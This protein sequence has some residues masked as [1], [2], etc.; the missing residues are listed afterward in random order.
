MSICHPKEMYMNTTLR[1]TLS[2]LL[3]G[4][5]TLLTATLPKD[6]V[7]QWNLDKAWQI[8]SSHR[9]KICI[10]GLWDFLPT[11][12]QKP[13]IKT[14]LYLKDDLEDGLDSTWQ[15]LNSDS[16]SIKAT[17]D[18]E[19]KTT[20]NASM[21]F[22]LDVK[23]STNLYH[24]AKYIKDLPTQKE[25]ILSMD[26]YTKMDAGSLKVEIQDAAGY[27]K[28]CKQGHVFT[29][30][31][32]WNRV[33]IPFSLP[34]GTQNTKCIIFRSM[35]ASAGVKGTIWIDN[36]QVTS[37]D[38][39]PIV[40]NN[41]PD[42]ATWGKAKVP[43]SWMATA[44]PDTKAGNINL[45]ALDFGWFKRDVHIPAEW[46]GRIIKVTFDRASTKATVF[47]NGK[48]AGHADF[49]GGDIDITPFVKAGSKAEIAVFVEAYPYW[50]VYQPLIQQPAK[51]WAARC[52]NK[53]ITGDVFLTSEPKSQHKITFTRIETIAEGR[54]LL[55]HSDVTAPDGTQFDTQC[56]LSEYPSNNVVKT[57]TNKA[58]VKNGR[59]VIENAWQDVKLWDVAKPNLYTLKLA[60]VKD[61][62][63]QDE[64]VPIR[65]GF[66]EFRIVGKH[67]YL[68]QTKINLQTGSYWARNFNWGTKEA[69]RHWLLKAQK[70]GFT[71]IYL[72]SMYRP[73][74]QDV[75]RHFLDVCD[76]IGMLAAI[77]PLSIRTVGV[78]HM[79]STERWD[80]WK[81]LAKH[82]VTKA[83]NSPSLVL[84]RMNMNIRCYAQDQNPLL[85]DGKMTFNPDSESAKLEK[86]A[87]MSNDYVN[88]IDPSRHTYNHASGRI[89][90]IYSLNNY[91]GWP[92]L[93]DLREW[94]R[95]WAK[96]GDKPFLLAEQATPYP[97]DFQM[98]DPNVWW[99]N[100]PIMTEYGAI[101]L[102][103][104]AYHLEEY[105]YV[106]YIKR[107]WHEKNK[108]WNSSYGY[109]CSNFPP[110]LDKS[111]AIYYETML[112]AWR[113][114]GLNAGNNAWENTFRRP[115]KRTPGTSNRPIP[116]P[117]ALKTDW[118][119]LQRP[120]VSADTWSYTSGGGGEMRTLFDLDL[121][122]EKEYL[123]PTIRGSL[124]PQLIAPLY[125]YIAGP[126]DAWYT[127]EHAFNEGETIAKSVIILNDARHE[128]TFTMNW[129]ATIDGKT[130]A[131]GT[132]KPVTVKP[133]EQARLQFNFKAPEVTTKTNAIIS[134]TVSVNGKLLPIKPFHVQIHNVQKDGWM[135]LKDFYVLDPVSSTSW[136]ALE[137]MR[138]E[139]SRISYTDELPANAK[140]LIIGPYALEQCAGKPIFK[141]IKER[142]RN[143]L[144]VLI[145]P[146]SA[147]A[148]N[149]VFGLRAFTPGIRRLNIRDHRSPLIG[150]IT[151][152]DIIDWRGKTSFGPLAGPPP[153]L[154]TKQRAMRVWRCSQEGVVASTVLEKPHSTAIR[155]ILDTGFDLRYSALSEIPEGKGRI[156]L[157]QLDLY[158]R[159]NHDPNAVKLFRSIIT[160]MRDNKSSVQ[161]V[162]RRD[163][164]L[165]TRTGVKP[166]ETVLTLKRGQAKAIKR[167]A[168]A[169][170]NYLANGGTI[171][172]AGLNQND[173]QALA[174]ATGNVFA[175]AENLRW[176]NLMLKDLTNKA[177]ESLNI[178]AV[179]A[180][181]SPA[182]I[183][184]RI[185]LNVPTFTKLPQ[186]AWTNPSGVLAN[187]PVGKGTI[188]AIP[189]LAED[190][191]INQRLDMVYS[192]VNTQRLHAI[193]RTNLG[194]PNDF[195]WAEK[196]E[197]P[198]KGNEADQYT[199][200]RL[201][202]D[203]PYADM[204]W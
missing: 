138:V 111:S 204:R 133:A 94:L 100:E 69:M 152:E 159:T 2:A 168:N 7:Q 4:A 1:S 12:Q 102:G 193:V 95:V 82:C 116:P 33:A 187:I 165:D 27:D 38:H 71:Y 34:K 150:D 202:R 125:A 67:L 50:L 146:Q 26:I 14:S 24:L 6:A 170:A 73:D 87:L 122:I 104:E 59:I 136:P 80:V 16:V 61:G 31:Q 64:T 175:T 85:L 173:M 141:N 19:L 155:H 20:G 106:D 43:G 180:G 37:I 161:T 21:K 182:E 101:V 189:A 63:R 79:N 147:E 30:K 178:P 28:Y 84:W 22:E 151:Q 74:Y 126:G 123:E 110:I 128:N 44:Y 132:H 149:K 108:S 35:G 137:P 148:L 194:L 127:V 25:L 145:L 118:D 48:K 129:K 174:A 76:E 200:K 160:S 142:V 60:I 97:G 185:K 169:I 184:W 119:N 41:V 68:N 183:Q 107:C 154:D 190:F 53:G 9:S 89:G 86:L 192:R 130:I 39:S 188:V 8:H 156:I 75:E 134:A 99:C 140:V 3:L 144:Q 166:L 172:A 163:V 196:L 70:A 198:A 179:F 78:A 88:S 171:I 36:V 46:K 57:F 49:L 195:S 143:G 81:Q 158:S 45:N 51:A 10:N 103:D 5:T 13:D 54:R 52:T 186:G 120:G 139:F 56:T 90:E 40:M 131:S 65:F 167:N 91:L 77:T 98:R 96:N 124:Y 113:T 105:D 157:C 29:T 32:G 164:T 55:V 42:N 83:I 115:F 177:K 93:Q 17:K 181:V 199:D 58:T 72:D 135:T 47:A 15:V 153:S 11:P 92:E 62:K 109:F 191:D 66:R 23:P 197:Q 117:V 176:N 114:W 203:D 201:L 162:L 18:T 112:P 121:P